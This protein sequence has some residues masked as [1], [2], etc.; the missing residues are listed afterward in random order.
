MTTTTGPPS[1]AGTPAPDG[2]RSRAADHG[3]SRPLRPA[4][5]RQ[6]EPAH[7]SEP[8]RQ[9]E[10]AHQAEA[11]R[12]KVRERARPSAG[13]APSS[14]YLG[15]LV[16]GPETA[17]QAILRLVELL[18]PMLGLDPSAVRVTLS[19]GDAEPHGRAWAG[20]IELT[21]RLDPEQRGTGELVVHE[22]AHARQH[23]NR[24][25]AL[26]SG[27]PTAAPTRDDA[28]PGSRPDATA[29]EAEAAGLSA[30]L[31][32]GRS[33]WVPA[34]VLPEGH[35]A[36]DAGAVGIA[37]AAGPAVGQ[38]ATTPDVAGLEV[39]LDALVKTNHSADVR[40]IRG[41]LDHPWTQVTEEMIENSLRILSGLPFVVARAL[42]RALDPEDRKKLARL[43]DSHHEAYPEACVAV[44]SALTATELAG[45]SDVKMTPNGPIHL[46][47]V[48]AVHGVQPERLS[49]VARRAL[50]VTLRRFSVTALKRLTD[51]DRRLVFRELFQS[52]PDSGTD[53]K[54]L[55]AAIDAEEALPKPGAA[56]ADD[57][58]FGEVS[59][60]LTAGGQDNAR[61]ALTALAPGAGL[62]IPAGEP[63][64]APAVAP[65]GR[66]PTLD[67]LKAAVAKARPSGSGSNAPPATPKGLVALVARLDAKG[68]VDKLIDGLGEDDRRSPTYGPVLKVVLAARSPLPNLSRAIELL[69]YGIFDWAVRDAEARLAYLLVRCTPV[70]A[71]D[72]WRQ[73]DN[74]KWFGRL[75]DNLPED[76]WAS[77]EYTGVGSEYSSGGAVNLGVPEPL[78]LG[79]ARKFIDL[80]QAAPH[81]LMAKWIVRNLLGL[82]FSGGA[83]PWLAAD[84]GQPDPRDVALRTAIIRRI[85]ALQGLN[86]IIARLPDDY[87]F[88][89][90][91]RRE[92]LDFNQLRDPVHLVRQARGLVPSG[93]FGWLTYTHRDAWLAAQAVRALAPAAQAQFA[94]ENPGLWTAIWSGLTDEMRR[95][96]PSTLATGR[97]ERLP[98]REAIRERLSDTRLWTEA[99]A[100]I[101]R[102]VIGLAYA[103]DDRAWVFALSKKL[104]VDTMRDQPQLVALVRELKL[105][106]EADGRTVYTPEFAEPSRAP[107][108]GYALGVLARGLGILLYDWLIEDSISLSGKTMRLKGFELDDLQTIAG[109]D[110]EGITLAPSKGGVNTINVDATFASGFIVNIDLPQLEIAGVNF[111]LPGKTY[112]SGPISIK[113]L[114]ASAGFSDRGYRQPGYI[115]A[116]L[117]ELALR[118]LVLIDPS[119]P[120]S[121]AWAVAN[122][123]LKKLDFNATP[124]G[125]TDPSV[126]L[127]RQLPKGT[128]PIPVFGPMIQLLANLVALKGAIPGDFTVLDYALLPAKLPFP[129]SSLVGLAA[130]QVVPTPAPASYLWGLASDG[131]LRPPYS[132]GQ[133]IKDSAAMLRAFNVSFDSL[134]IKGISIGSGQQIQSLT[135]TD[136]NLS[137]GQSLPAYLNAALATVKA[138]RAKLPPDS[139][140]AKELQVREDA[141]RAQLAAAAGADQ[142]DEKRLQELE[143]KDRWNPGS[144][145]EEERAELVRLTKKL[146]SDV[147]IVADIGSITL[148][149][150]S[151]SVQSGGVT[152]KG[153]HA[154]AKLPNVGLL[155][156]APGYLDD[157]SLIDQFKAGGPKVP[158][159]GELA[160]SGE[161]SLVVESTEMVS[162]DPSQ[163]AVILKAPEKL[164][165]VDAV[166][167]ELAALPNIEGN[168]PIRERLADAL[169]T[170][171]ALEVARKESAAGGPGAEA[172]AQRV[173]ELTDR[174]RRLLG[175]EIGGLK[176][177]RITGELDPK[178]GTLTAVV[179]DVEATAIAG[180]SFAVDKVTGSVSVTL[181]AGAVT[182]RPDQL[183][184]ATP[185]TLATQ[186]A[187]GFGLSGLTATGVHLTAGSIGRVAVGRLTGS[188]KTFEGGYQIPDLVVTHA[189]LDDLA[190]G[191]EG[192]GVTGEK[193]TVDN[194]TMD[195]KVGV[196]AKTGTVTGATIVTLGIGALGGEHLVLDMPQEE[197]KSIHAELLGGSL[198]DITG[199]GITFA[200]GS[201]G[202]ELV[203][204]SVNVGSFDDVR[205]KVLLGALTSRTSVAGRLTTSKEG[206]QA[207]RPSV[208]A[209]YARDQGR[210][211]SLKAQDLR[212]LGTDV[213]TPD[214]RVRIRETT[215]AAELETSEAGGRADA[216]LT[217][218]V[219]GP[220]RWKVGTAT[221]SGP[222]PLTAPKV[223]VAA[224]QT[225]AVPAQGKKP[226]K[227]AAWSITDIVINGLEGAGLT[228]SD[229][230]L[231]L[232]LGRTDKAGTGEP[233]LTVGRI[234]IRPAAKAIEVKNLAAD[235]SG[236]LTKT[237]GVNASVGIDF[238]SLEVRRGGSI[239][240]VIRGVSGSAS[241]T[242]DITTTVELSRLHGAAI[243]VGP[244]AIRIGSDDPS[245]TS[246]LLIEQLSAS[247]LDI[248]TEVAGKKLHLKTLTGGRIDLLGLRTIVRIDK[249]KPPEK[250]KGPFKQIAIEKLIIE[251]VELDAFQVDLPNDNVTIIVPAS[252]SAADKSVIRGVELTSPVGTDPSKLHPD[253]TIDLDTKAIEGTASI[254]DLAIGLSAK[255]KDKFSGDVRL[256]TGPSALY[257]YAGGGL[258]IDV[259][260]PL[261]TMAKAAEL[262]KDKR[263]RVAKLG[264]DSLTFSDGR[265]YVK[266]P[267]ARDLE[268]TQSID[269]QQAIWIKAT[270]INLAD[271]NY[272]TAA[273]GS[274]NISSLDVTDA[275]FALNLAALTRKDPKAPAGETSSFDV[276]KLR[277]AVDQ[278]DG[279]LQVVMY[280]SASVGNLKDFRIGADA[281]PLVVPIKKGEVDI[282]TF[283]SNLKGKV[284]A[285][286]IGSGFYLRPWVLNA[287][288]YDPVLRLDK[289]QL[290]LGVYAINPPDVAKGN[291]PEGKNR[292]NTLLWFDIL[293][294]DLRTA[295]L[296]RARADKF[297]LWAAIF[298]LHSKPPLTDAEL[299]AESDDDRTKRLKK[300]AE[301]KATIDSLELRK[302]VADLS[303][304]NASPLPLTISSDAAKGSLVL[305]K[306]ALMNLRV[307]GGISAVKPPPER[308]GT[309]PNRLA[310]SLDGFALDSVNLTLY[311]Y[312]PP[313]APG[314]AKK[315]TGLS[316]LS[317]GK[318]Q[319]TDLVGGSLT[320][321]DLFHPQ[322]LTGTIKKAHAENIRWFKY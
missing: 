211:I 273:G 72:T 79:Y 66:P 282:P 138:A 268:Y 312:A 142:A 227:P 157:K 237:L 87:L 292:P 187:P 93:F 137:I 131:V 183:G 123:G 272:D 16:E 64:Q 296:A 42:V 172:A 126:N 236:D 32:A 145:R 13:P 163:P 202:W 311:D 97:D 218:L 10:P 128:I 271:L 40:A 30:A 160:R 219:L 113:G 263:I 229:K 303:I 265:L 135:L 243:D 106:S 12:P 275:R 182:A 217:G 276:D 35:S 77:G 144:L 189:E 121:G 51:G 26:R 90:Q 215:V 88:G 167:A 110:L 193:V 146:R 314:E 148:G 161:F 285:T 250:G 212:A 200:P 214:G 264:A 302:L 228:Y 223:T 25:P 248:T 198:H 173:R 168:R 313:A 44:L 169:A 31:R 143:G 56:G 226:A 120:L 240:A 63:A 249:R 269:G 1:T 162:T 78:L 133:R 206:R 83:N 49:A 204:A 220:I 8:V 254:T 84:G 124:D 322:R 299:K 301:T 43:R 234:H 45:L 23:A 147:G 266:K 171:L 180:R 117:S 140:Q 39:K 28:A 101:L 53:E 194:L 315:L 259:A 295:D 209:S 288:A 192:D 270:D 153:I 164:P 104:R 298:D 244:D 305:S 281:S 109:G 134:D 82:D 80:Y 57:T 318:I 21:G 115:T 103:A 257:L 284:A 60:L 2:G 67:D 321:S 107:V 92:L 3:R 75:L 4:V 122:L 130:N 150:L 125:A 242:G 174:A 210:K 185:A 46:G 261:L 308:P 245:D 132:A 260:R 179:S 188:L 176:F 7:H 290:Q 213:S 241:L 317:T 175:T 239:A 310:I 70:A 95:Q 154:R 112:K 50:L 286:Q 319:I 278:L 55:R 22:L 156:Y 274:L 166:R 307:N 267:F 158:T 320:F 178:T 6:A 196:D 238:L 203:S 52:G 151:G 246:G 283:E 136:V 89:E 94:A 127:G 71:Q 233:P 247:A 29:A 258:R 85:D 14:S 304:R 76:L 262:G 34:T 289:N 252:T 181:S 81:A 287:V 208:V 199:T 177:G 119:L 111:V 225:P 186:L 277:P 62:A 201:K 15:P 100:P 116:K 114:K 33:L 108:W 41:L 316:S 59:K 96:L 58:L 69:S 232:S 17:G 279:S 253:F 155:P 105:Y 73:L 221:I 294:W 48:A 297:S 129:A 291:D 18:A 61:K 309:N 86:D 5:A 197:G 165:S 37:P 152:L 36:R 11:V 74:A 255:I 170:L 24:R 293:S 230:E 19:P 99:N 149:P 91:G 251:R 216:T 20:A 159:I 300:E 190:I 54:E 27:P 207:G 195:V 98:T 231:K 9:A 205:Y 65:A 191:A 235:L 280:V 47:P 141:L 118:D 102:A 222:G 256:T 38:T 68:L 139:P 224:V 184:K 306:D